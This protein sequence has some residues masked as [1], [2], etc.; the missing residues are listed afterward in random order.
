MK[1]P[2]STLALTTSAALALSLLSAGPA[3]ADESASRPLVSTSVAEASIAPATSASTAVTTLS[4]KDGVLYTTGDNV[5][6]GTFAVPDTLQVTSAKAQV[7][8]NGKVRGTVDVYEPGFYYPGSWGA[9]VVRLGPVTIT[10]YD[11]TTG[12]AVA[13]TF[14]D[15]KVSNT[16]RVRQGVKGNLKIVRKGK[17]LTFKVTVKRQTG[18]AWVGGTKAIVQYKKGKK[19]KNVKVVK[20]NSKGVAKFKR[21]QKSKRTYRLL[22]KTT[23]TVQGGTSTGFKI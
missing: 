6:S 3:L 22:V 13:T 20:V 15:P 9:G 14:T 11:Y 18:T 19:W 10:G 5:V 4:F 1:R 12:S 16:F 7:T 21:T 8:V 17:K 2:L 23:N